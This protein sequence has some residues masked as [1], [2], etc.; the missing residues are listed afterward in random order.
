MNKVKSTKRYR[1]IRILNNK[2]SVAGVS[3]PN[4]LN[5]KW[6]NVYVSICE[7][8][9]ALVLESGAKTTFLNKDEIKN[10]SVKVGEIKL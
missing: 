2:D 10:L 8:G 5:K 1:Q 3:L 9:T 6:L 4:T 7:S